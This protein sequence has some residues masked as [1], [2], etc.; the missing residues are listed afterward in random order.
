VF[1]KAAEDGR[2]IMDVVAFPDIV[3]LT[4]ESV[5]SG[6][7]YGREY[8]NNFRIGGVKLTLDGSPQGR[9]AWL[10]KPYFKVPPGRKRGYAGY[11]TLTDKQAIAAVSRAFRNNWQ[12]MVHSNGDAATDQMIRAVRAASAQYPGGDRRPVLVHGQVLRENQIDTLK[13]L[14]IF[15]SL[16]PMHTFYWG[17]WHRDTVLGRKRAENISPTG[18][19]LKRGMMFTTHHDAPVA[20]PDTMRVLSATVN[21]TTRSG[22]VLGPKQRVEPL[23]ALK[24]M[25]LWAAYELFEENNKGSIEPGKL[26]DFAILSDNPLSVPRENLADIKVVETIKADKRIFSIE[27]AP[28]ESVGLGC[29]ESAACFE[30]FAAFRADA[31]MYPEMAPHRH[32]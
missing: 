22:K 28:E 13:Q 17:D 26:A 4:D 20:F 9:T 18:W 7:Y 32:F 5:M 8:R 19:F 12:V 27:A 11:S 29:A 24:A 23:V 21:R 25:T 2:L 15:P 1:I 3:M 31:G 10:S 6:P 14:G 16:F 30:R